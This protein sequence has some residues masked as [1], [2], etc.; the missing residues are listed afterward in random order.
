MADDDAYFFVGKNCPGSSS[1]MKNNETSIPGHFL[2]MGLNDANIHNRGYEAL[3]SRMDY[4]RLKGNNIIYSN[5]AFTNHL[6]DQNSTWNCLRSMLSGWNVRV[7]IGYRHYFDWIRSF[8]YQTNKQKPK[9]E[10]KWPNQDNGRRHPSF[11][12]FLEYHIQTKES[13]DLSI[14]GGLQNNAF[15]HHLSIS[16]YKKFSSHF[17]DIKFLNIYDE[18]MV[19]DFVCRILPD[20][21]KTCRRLR[22]DKDIEEE[23]HSVAKRASQSFDAHRISEA[24][25][26]KGLISKDSPKEVVVEMVDNVLKDVGVKALS[27]FLNCPSPPLVSRFLNISIDYEMEILELMKGKLTKSEKDT[28]KTVHLSMY[29]KSE[30][31]NRFCDLDPELLLNNQTWVETLS[32]IGRSTKAENKSIDT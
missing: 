2:M 22:F 16:A 11:I 5:E 14:D 27:F 29:R 18:N 9:Q 13:G 6:I 7:V 1:K 12:S 28:A 17:D 31:E 3:K 23:T 8:Y 15:G 24:A 10:K 30:A 26:D 4:H 21:K 20:A 25:F 19:T 32:T